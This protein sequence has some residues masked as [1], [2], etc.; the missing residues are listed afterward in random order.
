[1]FGAMAS[2][3]G[4]VRKFVMGF[5]GRVGVGRG[6]GVLVILPP[7]S[8]GYRKVF[9]LFFSNR[10]FVLDVKDQNPKGQPST[11]KI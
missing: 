10:D 1:M 8:Y 2:R 6:D 7:W 9:S 5:V 4:V 11:F 3:A